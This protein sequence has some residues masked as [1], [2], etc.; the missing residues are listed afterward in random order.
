MA[1]R[2]AAEVLEVLRFRC[3]VGDTGV[4]GSASALHQTGE[5]LAPTRAAWRFEYEPQPFL[6]QVLELAATE[7]SASDLARR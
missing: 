3:E 4:H 6:D 2:I 7:R 5:A 1:R